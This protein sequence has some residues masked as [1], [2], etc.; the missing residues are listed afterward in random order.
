MELLVAHIILGMVFL[1]TPTDSKLTEE[2]IMTRVYV[3]RDLGG[4]EYMDKAG[5]VCKTGVV[6]RMEKGK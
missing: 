2:Q 5:V 3:C 4:V 6:F 1:G